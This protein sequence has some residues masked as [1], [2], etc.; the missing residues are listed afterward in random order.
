MLEHHQ[1]WSAAG[2]AQSKTVL[3]FFFWH[4][5]TSQN[6]IHWEDSTCFANTISFLRSLCLQIVLLQSPSWTTVGFVL[7]FSEYFFK[8]PPFSQE[9]LSRFSRLSRTLRQG[10]LN[11]ILPANKGDFSTL[12]APF[13]ILTNLST[14][15]SFSSGLGSP[16]SKK[17]HPLFDQQKATKPVQLW[18]GVNGEK[19]LGFSPFHVKSRRIQWLLLSR[20]VYLHIH[21]F[22]CSFL[23]C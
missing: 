9:P 20:I 14:W 1:P 4:K 8:S 13:L 5:R 12:G 23:S 19:N 10:D 2:A 17:R 7:L 11:A 3:L 21:F 15:G 22:Y 18:K 16:P 6:Q